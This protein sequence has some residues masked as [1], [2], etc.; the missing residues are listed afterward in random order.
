MSTRPPRDDLTTRAFHAQHT[1]WHAPV[2]DR[3]LFRR[4]G[5]QAAPS[6]R[7]RTVP[8]SVPVDCC[9]Q[10]LSAWV[11]IHLRELVRAVAIS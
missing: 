6:S 3:E 9:P 4:F 1:R 2:G 11:S 10:F 7:P 5:G 8:G